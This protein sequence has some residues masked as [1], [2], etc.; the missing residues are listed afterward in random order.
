MVSGEERKREEISGRGSIQRT[1]CF[2]S[3]VSEPVYNH[4]RVINTTSS[5]KGIP[6]AG[7]ID[8][9]VKDLS[10]VL[11]AG[12]FDKDCLTQVMLTSMFV[13]RELKLQE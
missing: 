13:D 2:L 11:L 6:E 7:A 4:P 3:C 9:R 12:R 5:T 8:V 10:R 1:V